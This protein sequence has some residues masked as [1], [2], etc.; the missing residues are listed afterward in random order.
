MGCKI[1]K[2]DNKTL[3]DFEKA[4]YNRRYTTIQ[5]QGIDPYEEIKYK[6]VVKSEQNKNLISN[7]SYNI[8]ES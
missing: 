3:K 2:L 8:S 4:R 1:S 5:T 6:V 7:F